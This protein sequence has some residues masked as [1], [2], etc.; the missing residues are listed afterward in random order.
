MNKELDNIIE[1]Y[2][3]DNKNSSYTISSEEMLE[4]SSVSENSIQF[5][6]ASKKND[7]FLFYNNENSMS[8]CKDDEESSEID[9]SALEKS[10]YTSEELIKNKDNIIKIFYTFDTVIF[11]DDYKIKVVNKTKCTS[12]LRLRKSKYVNPD[13]FPGILFLSFNSI[14]L[15]KKIINKHNKNITTSDSETCNSKFRY[16]I[17][18]DEGDI[19][20]NM[21]Y[22]KL[23]IQ[24]KLLFVPMSK[25]QLKLT[26]YRLRGFCQ[27]MEELGAIEI[28]IEFNHENTQINNKKI[29]IKSSDY[30]YI[31]GTMGFS[32][33]KNDSDNKEITYKLIYP[34]NNTFILNAKVIKKKIFSNKY[35]ISKKN[36]VSNLELQYIIDSRCRHFITNY[37]TVFTLDNSVNYDYKLMSKLEAYN[38][39]LGFET[40]N[41]VIKNLKLSINTKVQFCDQKSSYKNLLGDNVS[42]D[43]IG[44]NYLLG[45]LNEETFKTEG[46][47][48]II[49][50]VHKYIDKVVYYKNKD[51]YYQIKKIYKYMNKEF[52]FD[53]YKNLLLKYFTVNSHWLHFLNFIDILV[54]KSV[55]YDKLG[56]LVLMSQNNIEPYKKHQ[57]IINFIRHMSTN[58]SSEDQ[59]WEMLEPNNYYLTISKLSKKYD[60]LSDFNWFNLEKLMYDIKK[61]KSNTLNGKEN[62]ITYSDL[63]E[64][65]ILGHIESQ[66]ERNIKPYM[67]KFIN[68]N[69]SERIKET[70]NQLSTVIYDIIRPRHIVY[71]N[72]NT[73]EKLNELINNK[74]NQ[75]EEGYNFF[76]E[77]YDKMKNYT[78]DNLCDPS[79]KSYK[80]LQEILQAPNFK[81]KYPYINRKLSYIIEDYLD[82]KKLSAICCESGMYRCM[83][84]ICLNFIKKI[85]LFDYK[86]DINKVNLDYIGYNMMMKHIYTI[87]KLD[88]FK[89]KED[90]FIRLCNF[91]VKEKTINL[92]ENIICKSTL[93]VDLKESIRETKE[94]NTLA[95]LSFIFLNQK[96]NLN[97]ETDFY[98]LIKN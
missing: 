73:E 98:R 16:H 63:Y 11:T 71:Y 78:R 39:N 60:L 27:I 30:S 44:F 34:K 83:R 7:E 1:D 96:Y 10:Y 3:N 52:S 93:D 56:F 89:L 46:I 65:L 50:F 18:F 4:S 2:N 77:V 84:K 48:K 87:N 66:F 23:Q 59:F 19:Y 40:N 81:D 67:I 61:Y 55:S 33:S 17:C 24:N 62:E 58:V 95:D 92:N 31:A 64:N 69:F 15:V 90:F 57:K 14:N 25:Y 20:K 9:S 70:D 22:K 49:F 36:F 51:Y 35:I 54:F 76:E 91:I 74:F 29:E 85:I 37:S 41:E 12:F 82:V 72:V 13:E 21:V 47:Y 94:F 68:T 80:D 53:E 32:A 8:E 75:I 43:S 26:E 38:F 5:K 28:E 79:D 88:K 86:F 45:T 42:W 6:V 97:L